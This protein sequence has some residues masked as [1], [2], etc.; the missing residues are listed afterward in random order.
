MFIPLHN[1]L[2]C[3]ELEESSVLNVGLQWKNKVK[4]ILESL[5]R[6]ENELQNE[7]NSEKSSTN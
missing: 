6:L 4:K 3:M 1:D 7:S 5:L 2:M